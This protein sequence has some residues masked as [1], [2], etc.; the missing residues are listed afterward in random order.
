MN[1]LILA[2]I[3]SKLDPSGVFCL[4]SILFLFIVFMIWFFTGPIYGSCTCLVIAFFFVVVAGDTSQSE[5]ILSHR[6]N[7]AVITNVSQTKWIVK[8]DHHPDE[9]NSIFFFSK[10]EDS[11]LFIPGNEMNVG[12]D[13][14]FT[15]EA[16][17][18]RPNMYFI[19]SAKDLKDRDWSK[20]N[21]W[22]Y[23]DDSGNSDSYLYK[24]D[25]QYVKVDTGKSPT[26]DDYYLWNKTVGMDNAP[27]SVGG[28][29]IPQWLY[30]PASP[31]YIFGL[32][33]LPALGVGSFIAKKIRE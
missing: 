8:N 15:M 31:C 5:G 24:K 29:G 10:S 20:P 16:T 19:A 6:A 11:F 25:G 13:G 4:A 7:K 21:S 14:Y 3:T 26:D 32:F 17:G 1:M 28:M 33:G 22:I 30:H 27:R 9:E 23:P 18:K 2:E 12:E